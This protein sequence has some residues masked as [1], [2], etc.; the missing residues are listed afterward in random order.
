MIICYFNNKALEKWANCKAFN[1]MTS[2]QSFA[3]WFNYAWSFWNIVCTLWWRSLRQLNSPNILNIA[4][5]S[6]KYVR[7]VFD[8]ISS[9]FHWISWIYL[10][11]TVPQPQE[12]S[13]ALFLG[14]IWSQFWFM[15]HCFKS[16]LSHKFDRPETICDRTRMNL[17]SHG[18]R[19]L[20]GNYFEPCN[21]V[22][23]NYKTKTSKKRQK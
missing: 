2:A 16:Y 12:V 18:V 9:K 15:D 11:F 3:T 17:A 20:T 21:A 22:F 6:F 23:R 14:N 13:E 10:N 7:H 19:R 1:I 5:I 4:K 8:K